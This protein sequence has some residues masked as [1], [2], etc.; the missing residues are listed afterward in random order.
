LY[1]KLTSVYQNIDCVNRFGLPSMVAMSR[2]PN[3]P[4]KKRFV[5]SARVSRDDRDALLKAGN[6]S[7]S[8]GLDRIL[9]TTITGFWKPEPTAQPA[10]PQP[11]P[12][13]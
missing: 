13:T 10:P 9:N 1:Y 6:G 4:E 8:H 3:P 11:A 2:R 7:I 12:G 5:I